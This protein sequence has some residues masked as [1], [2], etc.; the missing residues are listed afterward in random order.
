MRLGGTPESTAGV[1]PPRKKWIA[2]TRTPLF[3]RA[4]R[5]RMRSALPTFETSTHG[6]GSR[7]GAG[8]W[9]GGVALGRI[10]AVHEDPPRLQSSRSFEDGLE[11][12]DLGLGRQ[13]E[14]FDVEHSHI[15]IDQRSF[16]F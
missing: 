8:P 6:I 4:A 13:A 3:S 1:S 9:R 10:G 14:N 15:K 11:I 16:D 12:A 2:S 5:S 7:V